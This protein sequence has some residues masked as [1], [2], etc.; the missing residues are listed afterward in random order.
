MKLKKILVAF[1]V[2]QYL[3]LLVAGNAS[4]QCAMCKAAAEQASGEEGNYNAVILYLMA[5][6]YILFAVIVFFWFK[7]SKQAR[8][9]KESLERRIKKH[10]PSYFSN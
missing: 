5:F 10:L 3:V 9:K 7:Q 6:P 2:Q 8:E 1:L 4:A